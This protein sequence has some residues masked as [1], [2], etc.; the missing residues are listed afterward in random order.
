MNNAKNYL[1]AIFLF[2]FFG[3]A[4]IFSQTEN[5]KVTVQFSVDGLTFKLYERP[6]GNSKIIGDIKN[7]DTIV[8]VDRQQGWFKVITPSAVVGWFAYQSFGSYQDSKT[9]SWITWNVVFKILIQMNQLSLRV[10]PSVAADLT[11]KLKNWKK[12]CLT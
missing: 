3:S 1:V 5:Y 12:D 11:K 9:N 2:F 7:N 4:V 6:D 8:V 10:Y